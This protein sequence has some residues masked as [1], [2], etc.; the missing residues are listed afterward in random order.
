MR[1]KAIPK[2]SELVFLALALLT[3][4]CL[5]DAKDVSRVFS[6]QVLY[7]SSKHPAPGVV[8]RLRPM[9]DSVDEEKPAAG[10]TASTTNDGSCSLPDICES[11]GHNGKFSFHQIKTGV[12]DLAIYKDGKVFYRKPEPLVVPVMPASTTLVVSIP[13]EPRS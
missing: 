4:V 3:L 13:S 9:Y 1:L 8:I 6:G 11:A 5:S 2:Q 7:Q 10:E 12:Y